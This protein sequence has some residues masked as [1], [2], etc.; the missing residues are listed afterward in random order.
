MTSYVHGV[1]ATASSTTSGSYIIYYVPASTQTSTQTLAPGQSGFTST[2]TGSGSAPDTVIVGQTGAYTPTTS[3]LHGVANATASSTTSGSYMIY[4]VPASTQSTTQT[5]TAG[6]Q[7]FTSTVLGS[8]DAPDTLVVGQTQAYASTTSYLHGVASATTSST[9]SGS[10]IIYVVPASTFTTTQSLSP[11]QSAYSSTQLASGSTPDTIVV[12]QTAPFIYSTTY[13]HGSPSATPYSTTSGSYVIVASPASTIT[14][15][16]SLSPGQPAYLSTLLASGTTPDTV[17]VG[18]TAPFVY[19]T[20]YIHGSPSATAYST[21]SGSYI[22]VATPV[23]TSTVYSSLSPGQS[24][25]TSTSGFG[26]YGRCCTNRGNESLRNHNPV[27]A[28]AKRKWV[29]FDER[30]VYSHRFRSGN[31]HNF[32]DFATW[33]KRI[34]FHDQELRSLSA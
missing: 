4:Y 20:S 29:Y 18:Q 19:P 21:T 22:V 33:T 24:T 31:K 6:Q 8:G 3:Y 13:V 27:F 17:V 34:H 9:T 32:N 30:I 26:L 25:F 16:Q 11:G 2:A 23:S 28:R 10:Y 5:L 7:G 12:G 1:S 15:T 14:T